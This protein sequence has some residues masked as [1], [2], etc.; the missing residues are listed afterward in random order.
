MN[1]TYN[2]QRNNGSNVQ[3]WIDFS[4]LCPKTPLALIAWGKLGSTVGT[5]QNSSTYINPPGGWVTDGCSV[6]N[7]PFCSA[8][9]SDNQQMVADADQWNFSHLT[10][11]DNSNLTPPLKKLI[12]LRGGNQWKMTLPITMGMNCTNVQLSLLNNA[13]TRGDAQGTVP[14]IDFNE[15][16]SAGSVVDLEV[17]L[18]SF[19]QVTIGLRLLNGSQYSMFAMDWVIVR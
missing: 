6:S 16:F 7:E 2:P 4:N 13:A 5:Y 12:F 19:G 3:S 15:G 14:V 9:Q 18:L 1:D 11:S 10:R 8:L 17:T